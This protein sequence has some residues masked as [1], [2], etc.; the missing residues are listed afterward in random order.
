VRE[1]SHP[2]AFCNDN[3]KQSLFPVVPMAFYNPIERSSLGRQAQVEHT[4]KQAVTIRASLLIDNRS[5]F[6]G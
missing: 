3:Q 1:R 5:F 6:G 2:I 4:T